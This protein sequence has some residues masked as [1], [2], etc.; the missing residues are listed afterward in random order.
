MADNYKGYPVLTTPAGKKI[1]Y[2]K[3]PKRYARAAVEDIRNYLARP[4]GFFGRERRKQ[5]RLMRTGELLGMMPQEASR[6][7][8]QKVFPFRLKKASADIVL[9]NGKEIT[10][11]RMEKSG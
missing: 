8:Y 3:R 6:H 2:H 11:N 7:I 4:L 1:E 10:I 5:E 9:P